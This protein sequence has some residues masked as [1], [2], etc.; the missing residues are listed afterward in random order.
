MPAEVPLLKLDGLTK[1]YGDHV[2]VAPTSLSIQPR[3][4][5]AILGPSGCGKTT[6][7]RMIGGF[8]QPSGGTVQI[9]GADVTRLGPERRPTGMVFQNYGLFQHMTVRQNIAYGL[10]LRR[11]PK[12]RMDAAVD[13]MMA[14]VHLDHLAERA[15]PELSGGQRQRVALARAL[16][17][18]P[19]VLLLDEPLA[20]LD[21]KLRKTMHRELRALHQAIGGTFILVSH[22]Q[23]EVM[24][25]ANRVAVME[26]G[27]VVQEGSPRDIYMRPANVFV[28]GFIGEANTLRGSRRDGRIELAGGASLAHA[29]RDGAVSVVLRPEQ[30]ELEPIEPARVSLEAEVTD[31]IFL[32][33]F[34]H[35][36]CT[37]ANG[38]ALLVH[39]ESRHVAAAHRPGARIR[40]GWKADDQLVLD[41]S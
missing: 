17:L 5:F 28:S 32:G 3:D 16:I 6:L 8:V 27:A 31:L 40:L 18:K 30:L 7:L 23:S 38:D 15:A 37:L 2:A 25:L 12:A 39:V 4:F 1:R 14:L 41:A 35:L 20:A 13:E 22:D 34:T 36:H 19:K 11:E 24:T 33:P 26:H 29:G 9:G 21:L 10:K